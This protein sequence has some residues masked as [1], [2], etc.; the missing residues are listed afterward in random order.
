MRTTIS[1]TARQTKYVTAVCQLLQA[2]RHATNL[3][4][5]QK[6]QEVY[7][8][9]SATTIHRI[10]ARLKERGVIGFAP[11]TTNGSERYDANPTPHHHFMCVS[12]N[13]VCDVPDAPEARAVLRQLKALSKDCA[14]AGTMTMQGV[15]KLCANK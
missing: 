6:V 2:V 14:I 10:S 12:C 15:C 5:L 7:P 9:V 4:I 1:D 8:D 3:E 13:R 11:K